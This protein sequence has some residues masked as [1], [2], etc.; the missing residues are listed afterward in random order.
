MSFEAPRLVNWGNEQRVAYIFGILDRQIGFQ[1]SLVGKDTK[2]YDL[3]KGEMRQLHFRV[4]R[5]TILGDYS[6]PKLYAS[7]S[8]THYVHVSHWEGFNMVKILSRDCT[9]ARMWHITRLPCTFF[10]KYFRN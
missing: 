2:T 10:P 6:A 7:I 9:S 8:H 4:N 3:T 5:R 1:K